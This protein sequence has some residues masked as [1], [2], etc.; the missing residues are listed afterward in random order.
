MITGITGQDGILLSKLLT[1]KGE[2]CFGIISAGSNKRRINLLRE[3]VPGIELIEIS[4][5]SENSFSKVL[6]KKKPN[7]I[8]NFAAVSSVKLSFENPTLTHQVNFQYLQNLL[9]ATVKTLDP[10][11]KIFQSSS[12]EMFGNSLSPVQDESSA[13]NPVSPYGESK[14][15]AHLKSQEY[16]KSGLFVTNGILF[17]HESEFRKEGFLLDKVTTYMA[18]RKLGEKKILTLGALDV[19][20]DWGYAGDFVSGIEKTLQLEF[21]DDF[22]FAT[23]KT[24]SIMQLLQHAMT[25]IEDDTPISEFVTVDHHLSRPNEKYISCGDYSKAQRILEWKPETSFED[26][27]KKMIDFK[28]E[29]LK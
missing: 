4:D 2:N 6:R 25:A 7:K 28:V 1:Q 3:V 16:R 8:Y 12:S 18:A 22:V 24:R 13:L 17:N 5:Y 15:L 14:A 19:S 11:T 21:S 20:R 23:G 29:K 10:E 27:L 26:M 9:E